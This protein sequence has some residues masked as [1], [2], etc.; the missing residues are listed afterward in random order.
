MTPERYILV[1]DDEPGLIETYKQYLT[2]RTGG[3]ALDKLR[4]LKADRSGA[5]PAAE[6]P[7]ADQVVPPGWQLITAASGEQAL[8]LASGIKAQG[9]EICVAFFDVKM[10]PGIDGIEAMIRLLRIFPHARCG[11][12]SA[13]NDRSVDEINALFE[14]AHR[15]HWDFISKPFTEAEIRQKARVLA[16]TWMANEAEARA[17]DELAALNLNLERLVEERTRQLSLAK[18]ALGKSEARM[19]QELTAAAS[20]QMM[21][22]PA[23]WPNGQGLDFA[24]RIEPCAETGGDLCGHLDL[25][26][27]RIAT[28][29]VDVTGHGAAAALGTAIIYSTLKGI[30][31]EAR[32]L[33]EGSPGFT[34]AE[35]LSRLNAVIRQT[36]R[37]S[38]YASCFLATVKQGDG[39]VRYASAGH[40]WP[41]TVKG[42]TTSILPLLP[43]PLLGDLEA[44]S[45]TNLEAALN[46]GDLILMYTD[47]LTDAKDAQGRPFDRRRLFRALSAAPKDSAQGVLQ[48]IETAFRAVVPPGGTPEDDITYVILKAT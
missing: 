39:K 27:G 9:G 14:P 33:P 11:I 8:E 2:P 46:P 35:V 19:R 44:P 30:E 32:R 18:D 16:A 47:G 28:Y 1:T 4:K 25:G 15:N 38:L 31:S 6:G 24:F 23:S 7:R 43:S 36:T 26:E 5:A 37:G 42:G 21:L 17:R 20:I 12:V 3:S 13:Y 22:F 41:L 40:E 29:I 48:A 45:Y 10:A 34:P